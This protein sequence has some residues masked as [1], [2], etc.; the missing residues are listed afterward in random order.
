[1]AFHLLQLFAWTIHAQEIF[2]QMD[3]VVLNCLLLA[4]FTLAFAYAS[5]KDKRNGLQRDGNLCG[6]PLHNPDG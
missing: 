3:S 4:G 5:E 1:V 2:E 6:V